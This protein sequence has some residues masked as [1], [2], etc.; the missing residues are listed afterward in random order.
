MPSLWL[1]VLLA[2]ASATYALPWSS[3]SRDEYNLF[4]EP[5]VANGFEH[6]IATK[7]LRLVPKD[8]SFCLYCNKRISS[9]NPSANSLDMFTCNHGSQFHATCAKWFV[10][11]KDTRCPKD[12]CNHAFMLYPENKQLSLQ[13]IEKSKIMAAHI[14][15]YCRAPLLPKSSQERTMYT[16]ECSKHHRFHTMCL[17]HRLSEIIHATKNKRCTVCNE[18]LIYS[19]LET[20]YMPTLSERRE[21]FA[22]VYPQIACAIDVSPIDYANAVVKQRFADE[23]AVK[24][25]NGDIKPTLDKGEDSKDTDCLACR[26]KITDKYP[27]FHPTSPLPCE[28]HE[29]FHEACLTNAIQDQIGKHMSPSCMV[30]NTDFGFP[31][32][33]WSMWQGSPIYEEL[34]PFLPVLSNGEGFENDF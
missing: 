27:S 21:I 13:S 14:C 11:F 5:K 34:K 31:Q 9:K 28:H 19:S 12:D 30:C 24:V 8:V 4:H 20:Q 18:V 1:L 23:Y 2:C 22:S 25:K 29:L 6:R 17:N 10:R 32:M 26:E 3:S 33:S 16:Y 15:E 7:L